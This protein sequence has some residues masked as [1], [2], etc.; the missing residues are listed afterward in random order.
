M[1]LLVF[2]GCSGSVRKHS[3]IPRTNSSR[4][5]SS[6]RFLRGLS[7]ILSSSVKSTGSS[8]SPTASL[9]SRSSRCA[10]VV[11]PSPPSSSAPI[12]GRS[13]GRF[14]GVW[15][16]K[17]WDMWR[18]SVNLQIFCFKCIMLLVFNNRNPT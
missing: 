9:T 14:R 6:L 12:Y 1:S 11:L 15:R 3:Q 10:R 5:T 2:E 7:S 8:Q 4:A 17:R 16:L 13:A 18:Y